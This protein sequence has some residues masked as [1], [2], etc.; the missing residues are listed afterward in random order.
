MA[1][2]EGCELGIQRD[3]RQER[4]VNLFRQRSQNSKLAKKSCWIL[5]LKALIEMY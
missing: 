5:Q 3:G 1:D 2:K 4:V